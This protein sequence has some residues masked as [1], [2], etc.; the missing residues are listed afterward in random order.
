LLVGDLDLARV[1][2]VGG[3][4]MD[5][6]GRCWWSAYMMNEQG[7]VSGVCGWPGVRQ[8]GLVKAEPGADAGTGAAQPRRLIY[9][10]INS[11]TQRLVL[12]GVPW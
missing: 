2:V 11:G 10:R 12:R 1:I 3:A 8:A 6:Q 4:G 7:R 5:L 9:V